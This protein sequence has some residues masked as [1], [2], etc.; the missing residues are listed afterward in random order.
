[1]TKE[2]WDTLEVGD[3][4]K[5]SATTYVLTK[6]LPDDRKIAF[7]PS[8]KFHNCKQFIGLNAEGHSSGQLYNWDCIDLIKRHEPEVIEI[9]KPKSYNRL[10][11]L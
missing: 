2:V 6:V 10:T 11:Y 3:T 5:L 9:V 7:D 8:D 1:M 4:V